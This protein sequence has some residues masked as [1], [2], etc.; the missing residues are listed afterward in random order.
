MLGRHR[1]WGLPTRPARAAAPHR[2]RWLTAAVSGF[3]PRIPRRSSR[4]APR[5]CPVACPTLVSRCGRARCPHRAAA[6][7]A[8]CAALS[9]CPSTPPLREFPSHPLITRAVRGLAC[10]VVRSRCARAPRRAASPAVAHRRSARLR[11]ARAHTP[12]P[13]GAPHP[14]AGAPAPPSPQRQSCMFERILLQ[15]L[16]FCL[17]L[18]FSIDSICFF[19]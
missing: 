6:P 11:T 16:F 2:P 9:P 19:C 1:P 4:R 10:P 8:R 3:A 12:P 7:S 13:V 17:R 15:L 18:S 14:P 5:S